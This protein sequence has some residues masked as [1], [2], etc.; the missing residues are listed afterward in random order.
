MQDNHDVPFSD[1]PFSD[2]DGYRNSGAA[3]NSLSNGGV[4]GRD[5]THSTVILAS[6][7]WIEQELRD[8]KQNFFFP[9]F[10]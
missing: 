9:V 7:W 8:N 2:L 4:F 10:V 1:L 5:A 6:Y 3:V